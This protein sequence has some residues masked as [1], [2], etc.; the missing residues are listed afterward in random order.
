MA[1]GGAFAASGGGLN[2]NVVTMDVVE[3]DTLLGGRLLAERHSVDA[4]PGAIWAREVAD[5][6]AGL[7]LADQLVAVLE[8]QQQ[9]VQAL[10]RALAAIAGRG[11]Q[12]RHH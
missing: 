10:G 3:G 2:E 12:D 4:R 6:L 11:D 1:V 5:E 7:V 8:M 9:D